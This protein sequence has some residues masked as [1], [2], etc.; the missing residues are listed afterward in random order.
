M[1]CPR[2]Q[3]ENPDTD[4]F[5]RECG[6]DLILTCPKCAYEILPLD[7]FCG[8]CRARESRYRIRSSRSLLIPEY[9]PAGWFHVRER[10]DTLGCSTLGGFSQWNLEHDQYLIRFHR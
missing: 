9:L 3:F 6:S 2:C 5:C 10:N 4:K 7:K 1:K 8:N